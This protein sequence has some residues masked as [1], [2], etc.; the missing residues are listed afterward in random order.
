MS[1]KEVKFLFLYPS[2]SLQLAFA[3]FRSFIHQSQPWISGF[4]CRPFSCRLFP[5][6]GQKLTAFSQASTFIFPEWQQGTHDVLTM[7]RPFLPRGW[8][9]LL[10]CIWG[11]RKQ[12]G[13]LLRVGLLSSGGLGATHRPGHL[14]RS[15]PL[16][17][18]LWLATRVLPFV[19]PNQEPHPHCSPTWQLCHSRIASPR[20]SCYATGN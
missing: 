2:F 1:L 5:S 7:K 17:F 20:L 3:A 4:S 11:R 6:M 15:V 19:S 13:W 9:L 18:P 12:G 16:S 8:K 14:C 10:S